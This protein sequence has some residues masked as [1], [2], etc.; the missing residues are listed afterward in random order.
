MEQLNIRADELATIGLAISAERR[1][2]FFIP[3]SIV[4]LR[5]NSTT[6]TSHYAMHLRKPAGSEDFFKWFRKNYQCD[7]SMINLVDW[8]AHLTALQKLSF[9]EKR[10]ITKFNFQWLP[11]GHQQHKVNPAQPTMYPSCCSLDVEET[12]THLYQCPQQLIPFNPLLA[13]S[14]VLSIARSKR[15]MIPL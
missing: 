5:V 2:C 1:I 6:M 4:E 14:L 11:T 10:F 15:I 12:K 13:S 3:E 7:T 8:D 9:S